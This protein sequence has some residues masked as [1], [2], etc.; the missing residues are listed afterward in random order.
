M[1]NLSDL[2]EWLKPLT[3]GS[4]TYEAWPHAM[5]VFQGDNQLLELHPGNIQ[6]GNASCSALPSCIA[7]FV[8]L[9]I[10]HLHFETFD[11]S[12]YSSES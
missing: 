11:A 3:M 7:S 6:E 12:V 2:V 1:L 4:P 8:A 10:M 5:Q 9:K